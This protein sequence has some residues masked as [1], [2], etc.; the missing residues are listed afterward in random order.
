MSSVGAFKSL[1]LGVLLVGSCVAQQANPAPVASADIRPA[2]I[3]PA[4]GVQVVASPGGASAQLSTASFHVASNE[5]INGMEKTLEQYVIAF[6]SLDLSQVQQV[7]PSLDKQ[8]SKAFKNVFASMKGASSKPRLAL[9]CAV[10]RVTADTASVECME[11][12]TY[13]VGKGKTKE[14]GPA[15]ISIELKGQTSHW[16]VQDMKGRG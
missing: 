5:E 7:W 2:I 6:E 1:F 15:K 13:A 9:Q 11:T 14:A 10:P 3:Q 4:Q 16:V 12:V 8:H